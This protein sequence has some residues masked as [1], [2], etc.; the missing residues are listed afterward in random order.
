MRYAKLSNARN[1]NFQHIVIRINYS[2]EKKFVLKHQVKKITNKYI[3]RGGG[4][5]GVHREGQGGGHR[6][7]FLNLVTSYCFIPL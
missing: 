6:G 7:G 1:K 2:L 4:Q 3:E 5:V